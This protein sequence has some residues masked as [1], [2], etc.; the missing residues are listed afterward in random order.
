MLIFIKKEKYFEEESK[1]VTMT[2]SQV[3]V[4]HTMH[5]TM[6]KIINCRS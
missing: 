6:T 5:L 4:T 3:T 2:P 1:T